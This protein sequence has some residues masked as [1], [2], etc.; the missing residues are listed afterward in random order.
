M[1]REETIE[2][3]K[4]WLKSLHTT[5][6]C[7]WD[8]SSDDSLQDAAVWL[9]DTLDEFMDFYDAEVAEAWSAKLEDLATQAYR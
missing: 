7:N 6:W 9:I 5:M 8:I 4:R 3:A 1:T 2:L